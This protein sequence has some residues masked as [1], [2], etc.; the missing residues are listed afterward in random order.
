[1]TI[2]TPRVRTIG[3]RL[4]EDEYALL[5]TFC[6][7]TGAQS[8]A[9]VARSAIRAYIRDAHQ[10]NALVLH[11]NRSS[12]QMKELE[13]KVAQLTLEIAQFRASTALS[14]GEGQRGGRWRRR[15]YGPGS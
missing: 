13:A 4:R 7:E 6:I 14:I 12:I 2:L 15:G 8:I 11:A 1:M 5:E 3:V 9:D 10:K